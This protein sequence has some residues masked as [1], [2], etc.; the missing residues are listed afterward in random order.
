MST[1]TV[2]TR[3]CFS[4]RTHSLCTM[5]TE[6]L[7]ITMQSHL[8]S[9]GLQTPSPSENLVCERYFCFQDFRWVFP[10]ASLHTNNAADQIDKGFIVTKVSRK[11]AP[12]ADCSSVIEQLSRWSHLPATVLSSYKRKAK[13]PAEYARFKPY[14]LW[15]ICNLL[16]STSWTHWQMLTFNDCFIYWKP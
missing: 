3:S 13:W 7:W 6:S 4:G 9:T 5:C 8:K 2:W 16:L 10:S 1:P 11:S 12:L 14:T 15:L